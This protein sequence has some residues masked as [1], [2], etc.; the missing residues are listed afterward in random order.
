MG[1]TLYQLD[2]AMEAV[3]SGGFVVDEETG[4]VLF[5]SEN[6]DALREQRNAKLEA[7]A[8]FVKNLDA[9]AAAIRAEVAALAA[10]QKA[11]ERKAERLRDYLTRSMLTG[12]EGALER[13]ET[14]RVRVTFRH[15]EAVG[16]DLANLPRAYKI[17][18]RTEQA[19][20]AAIK[21]ALKEGRRVRGAWIEQ[22]ENI[23]I[24]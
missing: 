24:R 5:D 14:P 9:E 17:T 12:A 7:V 11:A 2:E 3:I 22:R 23:Q 16:C 4:E 13:L 1:F 6:L 21:K 18:E 10:R 19:D 15:S 20:K 8:L